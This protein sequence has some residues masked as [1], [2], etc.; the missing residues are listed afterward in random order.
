[1]RHTAVVLISAL[2]SLL[3][4][5]QP[6]TEGYS[7]YSTL[8]TEGWRYGDTVRL[9]IR[10]P[11]SI[12]SGTLSVA[13]RHNN[14]YPYSEAMLEV[15]YPG[16]GDRVHRDTVAF[17]L[18]NSYGRWTGHGFGASYQMEVPLRHSV[19]LPDSATVMVRHVMRADTLRGIEQVGVFFN[20]A[21]R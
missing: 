8:P 15:T 19:R 7:A 3:C 6:G 10:V 1:M 9:I 5:C 20:P 21:E 12:A 13:V 2:S 17:P 18:S 11:D 16:G 14:D 4:G